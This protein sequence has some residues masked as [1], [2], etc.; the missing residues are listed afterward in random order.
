MRKRRL[1][2]LTRARFAETADH[3]FDLEQTA[4]AH[5][6]P[7]YPHPQQQHRGHRISRHLPADTDRTVELARPLDHQNQRF[8]NRRMQFIV[9]FPHVGIITVHRQQVLRQIVGADRDEIHPARQRGHLENRRRHL[10]HDPHFR[11]RHR[12]PLLQQFVVGALNQQ[13]QLIQFAYRSDHRQHDPQIVQTDGGTQ[14]GP[15]LGQKYLR[16]I[17]RNTNPTPSQKRIGLM[18]QENRAAACL[19]QYPAFSASPG[20][21]QMSP[22][23]N[24][25]WRS[26]HSPP[27]TCRSP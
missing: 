11:H 18:E 4:G 24:G 19:R 27:E 16:M 2:Q 5:T 1:Q 12:K 22:A 6:E 17:Q 10:H 3:P 15:Y 9:E 8:Q 7:V 14:H 23:H 21:A 26:G 25:N 20:A 13:H